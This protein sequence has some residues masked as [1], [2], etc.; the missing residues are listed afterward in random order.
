[1]K[2]ILAQ[3]HLHTMNMK[4]R[5]HKGYTLLEIL[6]VILIIALLMAFIIPQVLQGPAK[7]R[8]IARKQ[9]VGQL[10]V[11]IENYMAEQRNIPNGTDCLEYD[12]GFGKDLVDKGY[13]SKDKAKFPIDPLADHMNGSCKGLYEYAKVDGTYEVRATLETN[14]E[15]YA[16]NGK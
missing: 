14:D 3:P 12:S 4:P 15:V 5:T 11:A 7:A 13:V 2:H 9:H 8:D 1:M 6:I 16:V 10:S